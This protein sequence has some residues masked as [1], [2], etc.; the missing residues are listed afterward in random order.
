MTFHSDLSQRD[1]IYAS[2]SENKPVSNLARSSDRRG[3][4]WPFRAFFR[5]LC[6]L[7]TPPCPT[8]AIISEK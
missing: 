7:S 3:F 5:K 2:V 4:H 6:G 8:V 1:T